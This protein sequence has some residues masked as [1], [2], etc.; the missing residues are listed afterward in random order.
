MNTEEES[1]NIHEDISSLSKQYQ[2]GT[3]MAGLASGLI[4]IGGGAILVTLNRNLLKMDANTS[5]GTSYLIASTIVPIAL[6]SHLLLDD[7]NQIIIDNSGWI[8]I[9]FVLSIVFSS[10]YFGAKY[11]IKN[12]SKKI[13]SKVFLDAVL[14]GIIRYVIDIGSRL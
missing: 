5:S 7:V 8:G 2:A 11:A 12:I 14:L 9:I 4:G 6:V 3:S 13:V 10:A 1:H